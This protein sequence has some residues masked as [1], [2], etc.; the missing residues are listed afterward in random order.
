[1]CGPLGLN[2]SE[3]DMSEA[4][5]SALV[6]KKFLDMAD[7]NDPPMTPLKLMKMTYIAQG[8]HL[9]LHDDALINEEVCAWQFGPVFPSLYRK[10]KKYGRNAVKK[11]SLSAMEV[12][13]HI[14]IS[15]CGNEVINRVHK[16]YKGKTAGQLCGMTH[17]KGTPWYQIKEEYGGVEAG[18]IIPL[19]VIHAYYAKLLDR[20]NALAA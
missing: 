9:G 14:Q 6:A 2:R 16:A 15:D 13:G 4:V 8:W 7:P 19:H 18:P 1:M 20:P 10:V 11:I 17:M 3:T 5:S 12:I